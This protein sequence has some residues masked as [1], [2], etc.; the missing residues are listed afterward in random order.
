MSK[1][2]G[3][4]LD[5]LSQ[6]DE[7]LI[8]KVTATRIERQAV[9][10]RKKVMLVKRLTPILAAAA[11]LCLIITAVFGFIFGGSGGA[12]QVPIYTGMTVSTSAPVASASAGGSFFSRIAGVFGIQTLDNSN[13]AP[14]LDG[15]SG[16]HNGQIKHT[17]ENGNEISLGEQSLFYATAGQ[18]FYITV[19]IDN[20]DKFE[21]VSFTLNGEKYT[22]YMFEPGSDLENLILKCN[23]GDAVGLVQ[24]TI[25]AIKYIDGEEIKDVKIGG[26]Q[27]IDIALYSDLLHPSVDM[28][29]DISYNGMNI[30]ITL[31]D[32]YDRIA[33]SGGKAILSFY[34][35]GERAPISSYELKPNEAENISLPDLETDTLYKVAVEAEYDALDGNGKKINK[36][37]EEVLKTDSV[38]S[39]PQFS[40][41]HEKTEFSL[42]WHEDIA[43]G[44]LKALTL[45]DKKTGTQKSLPL[46]ASSIDGLYSNTEYVL[47]IECTV[48]GVEYV[49]E[50][51]FTTA[52]YTVPELNASQNGYFSSK[53]Q[54]V[55]KVSDPD[56]RGSLQN[57]ALYEGE[58]LIAQTT[59]IAD[60][61]FEGLDINRLYTLKATY[62]YDLNDGN[63]EQK[64]EIS[65]P[66]IT[67]S[68]GLEI[69]NGKIVGMGDFD[70]TVLYLNLPAV[71]G[72]IMGERNERVTEIYIGPNV[73]EMNFYFSSWRALDTV[74]ISNKVE[75]IGGGGFYGSSLKNVVFEEGSRLTYIGGSVF[76]RTNIR[77]ICLPD[78]VKEIGAN[79]F[80][81]CSQLEKVVFPKG[82]EK[83]GAYAFCGTKIINAELPQ[84]VKEIGE[85]AFMNGELQTLIIP[86]SVTSVGKNIVSNALRSTSV[87]LS[88]SEVPASWDAKWSDGAEGVFCGYT[89][90]VYN[91]DGIKYAVFTDGKKIVLGLSGELNGEGK[92]VIPE[93]TTHIVGGAFY[94]SSVAEVEL[95]DS[96][97]KI[98][99]RSFYGCASLK[100]IVIPASVLEIGSNAFSRSAVE[101]VVF[102]DGSLLETLE[103]GVFEYCA[104]LSEISLPESLRAIKDN[105]FAGCASLKAIT[106]PSGLKQIGGYAFGNLCGLEDIRIPASVEYIAPYAFAGG[107]DGYQSV[108]GCRIQG[109]EFEE[110]IALTKIDKSVF[111]RCRWLKSIVIPESVTVI[112]ENAFNDCIALEEAVLPSSLLEIRDGAFG[113]CWVLER[114]YISSSVQKVGV[115]IVWG[116][117]DICICVGHSAHPSGWNVAWT[118]ASNVI[119]NC[120]RVYTDSQGVVYVELNDGA[121]K[122]VS[123]EGNDGIVALPE[124]VVEIMPRAF[125]E[126]DI[127]A[128]GFPSTL[129]KIGY[130]AFGFN[131]GIEHIFIPKSV[132]MIDEAAFV[133]IATLKTVMFE[134]G[135]KIKRLESACFAEA[136]WLDTV[137]LPEGL[138]YIGDGA[139]SN[140]H[141]PEIVLPESLKYIGESAFNNCWIEDLRIPAGVLEIGEM[142]F[143]GNHIHTLEFGAG[144]KLETVGKGAFQ[145]CSLLGSVLLPEGLESIG[146][147]AFGGCTS[148]EKVFIPTSVKTVGENVFADSEGAIVYVGHTE[149]PAAWAKRWSS[150]VDQVIWGADKAQAQ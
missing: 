97:V 99:S 136:D 148:I 6:I 23:A 81:S 112:C 41:A 73:K 33:Q 107:T 57:I 63:G 114:L 133:G 28:K 30:S 131:Y 84:G 91:D 123:Y 110:G 11:C 108:A 94:K 88:S 150:G 127:D 42:K 145:D 111:Y 46:D 31:K 124:G 121:V 60:T 53:V 68:E 134:E 129:K 19:H 118:E 43:K 64:A 36:I 67:Q 75:S 79:A 14:N 2:N 4:K 93:G 102:E 137:I 92:L 27:T 44:T 116:N 90:I 120:K 125:Y 29:A 139:F 70:G 119:W 25:D 10:Q 141:L 35:D 26:D 147:A 82:L 50:K 98:G 56:R 144:S 128:I 95:P 72:G 54:F 69:E 105:V 15:N 106:L 96:L 100:D 74:F 83:I 7:E 17:D 37:Y 138:E 51:K 86:P 38:L 9:L 1:K 117:E 78:E 59:D 3:Y 34:K 146:D 62:I 58:A 130:Q 126:S 47:K 89:E 12:K 13:K 113:S 18:D 45:S 115:D 140:T 55:L 65:V 132:E 77:E 66:M 87:F 71:E 32:K 76:R 40:V 39:F 101:R 24:Y 142:A 149:K 103:N 109:I 61:R 52:S 122:V 16:N 104:Q 80:D 143:W 22:N 20:P 8:D 49:F 5:I 85:S 135:S 21:I 48:D